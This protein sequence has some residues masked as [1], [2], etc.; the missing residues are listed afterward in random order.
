M[1]LKLLP[2]IAL[3]LLLAFG[4]LHFLFYFTS[5]VYFQLIRHS[6]PVI[7]TLRVRSFGWLILSLVVKYLSISHS[8]GHEIIDNI[9][10]V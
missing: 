6:H 10:H 8:F 2:L 9:I 1:L 7:A 3:F 5:N 4:F